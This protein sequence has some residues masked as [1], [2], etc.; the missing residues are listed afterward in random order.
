M[1]LDRP[2]PP[3]PAIKSSRKPVPPMT[4]ALWKLQRSQSSSFNSAPTRFLNPRG[5][6]PTPPLDEPSPE[7]MDKLYSE[8]YKACQVEEMV[9]LKSGDEADEGTSQGEEVGPSPEPWNTVKTPATSQ[10][11][12]DWGLP[13]SEFRTAPPIL[14]ASTPTP[15]SAS[16]SGSG[17]EIETGSPIAKAVKR[18]IPTSRSL[19]LS[20]TRLSLT[21]R[22]PSSGSKAGGKENDLRNEMRVKKEPNGRVKDAIARFEQKVASPSLASPAPITPV[23]GMWVVVLEVKC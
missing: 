2:L 4:P 3:T 10:T 18:Y 13:G 23:R 22:I 15:A 16:G 12:Y 19:E 9:P 6:V 7:A 11:R 14:G 5:P 21:P 17:K 8:L 20:N 1:N